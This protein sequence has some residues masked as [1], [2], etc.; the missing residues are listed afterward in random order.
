MSRINFIALADRVLLEFS[1][2]YS[3][4]RHKPGGFREC[5]RLADILE[6]SIPPFGSPGIV[7]DNGG[8]EETA[9][10]LEEAYTL[11]AY[12]R[13]APAPRTG[14]MRQLLDDLPPG[15]SS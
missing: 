3:E 6:R 15:A 10:R 12:R 7:R 2:T 9:R 5:E 8:A 11:A 1:N 14:D 13:A 4:R